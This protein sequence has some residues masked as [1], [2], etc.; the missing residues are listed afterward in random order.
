MTASELAKRLGV[1]RTAVV[2]PL[3]QLESEGIVEGAER[4]TGGVGKPALEYLVCAGREDHAS[5]AYPPFVEILIA[6][7]SEHLPPGDVERLMLATGE[8]MARAVPAQTEDSFDQ[9]VGAA[10]AFLDD[11][12]AD[13]LLDEH[14]DGLML[15][16]FSC[17]LGRAVRKEGCVC[18]VVKAFLEGVTGAAVSEQCSREERLRCKFV[19]ET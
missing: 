15:R 1:T 8:N 4:K 7:A 9:R 3:K 10:R 2:V 19:L 11:L 16:S 6:T 12:G 18:L 13:T 14:E 5:R 17:P